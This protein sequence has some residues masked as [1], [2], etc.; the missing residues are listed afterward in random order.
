MDRL[1]CRISQSVIC[2]WHTVV[3][4]NIILCPLYL[5]AIRFRSFIR[6]RFNFFNKTLY[7]IDSM[8]SFHQKAHNV[9][10]SISSLLISMSI[11]INSLEA[12]KWYN[13]I[14]SSIANITGNIYYNVWYILYFFL[15]TSCTTL[16]RRQASFQYSWKLGSTARHLHQMRLF[17]KPCQRCCT[18]L[19]QFGFTSKQDLMCSTVSWLGRTEKTLSILKVCLQFL[20]WKL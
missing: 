9:L 8:V 6:F 7:F 13:F 12:G 5:L 3:S 4:F 18:A 16:I 2:W 1:C 11:S 14:T 17:K 19:I 20:K 15:E 10:F